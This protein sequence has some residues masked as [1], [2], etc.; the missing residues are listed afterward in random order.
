MKTT[1]SFPGIS[2]AAAGLL[3]LALL[4]SP[5]WAVDV[6][7]R[8]NTKAPTSGEIT[9]V[10]KT[11]V[12]VKP[13]GKGEPV[14]IPVNEIV[15]ISWTGDPAGLS[16][17]RSDEAGGRLQK[18]LDGYTKAADTTKS[19]SPLLK[20]DLE[21]YIARTT[22]KIAL[23]DPAK[24]DDAIKKLE[25][26][27]SAHGDSYNFYECQNFLGQLYA[28]KKDYIKAKVAFDSLGKAPWKDYQ[29]AAKIASG[30]MQLLE[31]KPNDAVIDFDAVIGMKADN[32]AEESQRQEA[33]LG[34]AKILTTQS[35]FDDALKLLAEVIEKAD[36]EDARVQAEAFVRQGD[37]LEASGK[38]K[39]ALLAYLHVDVLF[40]T[41]K[42]QHA[43][44]LFHLSR[45]WAK[46]GK[47][48]RAAEAKE[49][50]E[51]EFPNSEWTKQLK[52][53]T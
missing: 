51:S 7:V 52:T 9:D 28:A 48:G 2:S 25:A 4:S 22:A 29:M 37:C 27:K 12:T 33:M 38:T 23:S 50:L 24:I 6:V 1:P 44:A 3:T 36:P 26:F 39:D 19:T 53:S 43:E 16:L 17:S 30:R 10:S 46:D 34:K 15:S 32:P 20:A 21:F 35:K 45:L 14:K 40:Q 31:N 18:A 47:P 49:K 42:A 8:K 13:V 5:A 41:E 11:E